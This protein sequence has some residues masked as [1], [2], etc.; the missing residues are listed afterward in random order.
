[1]S[2]QNIGQIGEDAAANY[3]TEKGYRVVARNYRAG[4]GEIDLIAWL[5]DRLLVFVEIK[6]R[7][8][9]SFGGPEGAVTA[10]KQHVM[11]RTA[12]EYMIE[13]GYEWAVRFDVVAVI[14]HHNQVV[15]IRHHEDA[16]FPGL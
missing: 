8:S 3:L 14:V 16:F 13:I 12:G 9:E 11:A 10:R 2:N 5:D 6:T 15:E 1:M 7:S 4:R